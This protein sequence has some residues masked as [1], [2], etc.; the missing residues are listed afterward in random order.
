MVQVKKSD[1]LMTALR[2]FIEQGYHATSI[3]DILDQ[4]NISRGT[5]YKHFQTKGELFRD[6]LVYSEEKMYVERDQLLIG[7]DETNKDIFIRQLEVMMSYRIEK[8]VDAL[9][10][11]ALVSNDNEIIAFLK[12]IRQQWAY[13]F[14]TRMKQIYPEYR[15]YIADATIFLTGILHNANEINNVQIQPKPMIEICNYC[16]SLV[17]EVLPLLKHKRIRLFNIEDFEQSLLSI[18][19]VDFPY[20]DLMLSTGNLKKLIEKL[21]ANNDNK[22][23]ALDLLQFVQ[24]EAMS[25]NPR[26]AVIS[27]CLKSLMNIKSIMNTDELVIY[28]NTL[29]KLGFYPV[30]PNP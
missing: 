1:I 22:Q 29:K 26:K 18:G 20:N 2:L 5:F 8:K 23:H 4:T 19:Q 24:N 30:D 28:L 13:W 15:D 17:D 6:V 21:P 3:Q 25:E 16:F 12:E 14:F 10:M 11:D 7:Q 9:L 27:S